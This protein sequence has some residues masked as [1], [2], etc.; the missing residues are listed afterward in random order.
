[1]LDILVTVANAIRDGPDLPG[2]LSVRTTD[3]ACVYL[4]HPLLSDDGKRAIPEILKTRSAGASPGDGTTSRQ[5]LA[6]SRR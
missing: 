6:L 2:T 4:S 1:M 3:E 5:T